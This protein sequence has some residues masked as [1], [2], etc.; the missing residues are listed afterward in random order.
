MQKDTRYGKKQ[1]NLTWL[2]KR[3]KNHD[4]QNKGANNNKHETVVGRLQCE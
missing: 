4:Q 3:Y 2:N 1:L